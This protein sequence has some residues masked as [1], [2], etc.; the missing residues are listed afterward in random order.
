VFFLIKLKKD[1][2]EPCIG[3][4]EVDSLESSLQNEHS[5]GLK[6][7]GESADILSVKPYSNNGTIIAYRMTIQS[8]SL[9]SLPPRFTSRMTIH[10]TR[11]DSLHPSKA[12]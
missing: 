4:G 7:L 12:N 1:W 2:H 5:I 11:L 10:S 3:E 8:I 9:D 6:F